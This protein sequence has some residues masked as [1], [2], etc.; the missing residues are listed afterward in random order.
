MTAAAKPRKKRPAPKNTPRKKKGRITQQQFRF[1][2]LLV[3]EGK[4]GSEAARLAGY[5]DK[6]AAQIAYDL[7]H[8]KEAVMQLI[9]QRR[10]EVSM[11]SLSTRERWEE[12]VARIA[13]LDPGQLLEDDGSLKRIKDMPED[14]RRVL[15]GLEVSELFAGQGDDKLAIGLLKK[16]KLADKRA[17]LELLAKANGW[18]IDRKEI[19]G[20]DGAPIEVKVE[21]A[22]EKLLARLLG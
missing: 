11:R 15:A 7:T 20:K 13:F 6:A 10:E 5:S 18:I 8:K 19:T 9:K 14:A 12:E 1:V 22:R 4:S 21:D 3:V 17:A 2:E 16:V